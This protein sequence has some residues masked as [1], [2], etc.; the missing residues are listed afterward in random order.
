MV[1]ATIAPDEVAARFLFQ[2]PH[3]PLYTFDGAISTANLRS[4]AEGSAGFNA[5]A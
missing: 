2:R 1:S 4:E 5:G 3:A